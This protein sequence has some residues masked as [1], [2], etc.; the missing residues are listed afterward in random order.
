MDSGSTG[1]VPMR[2][3]LARISGN[4]RNTT[5]TESPSGTCHNPMADLCNDLN[6]MW[7][8][9]E[10]EQKEEEITHKAL[11]LQSL[12]SAR[13]IAANSMEKHKNEALDAPPGS[14]KR[15]QHIQMYKYHKKEWIN[16]MKQTSELYDLPFNENDHDDDSSL[17][18]EDD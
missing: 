8:E 7:T 14:R 4:Q 9:M 6:G 5:S 15:K 3:A 11:R 16:L 1:S 2:N 10:E 13:D 17:L 18:D 12:M